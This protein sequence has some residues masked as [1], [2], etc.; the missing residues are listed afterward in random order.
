VLCFLKRETELVSEIL[1]IFKKLEM[2]NAPKKKVL[3]VKFFHA[4][5]CLLD[6][7]TIETG[8]SR[9]SWNAATELTALCRALSQKSTDLT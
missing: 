5:F 7:L 6:F 9:L 2:G 1:F 8:T 3:S 4:V